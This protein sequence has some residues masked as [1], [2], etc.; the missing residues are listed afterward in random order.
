M[1]G[2]IWGLLAILLSCA[3]AEGRDCS[4]QGYAGTLVID[5][6]AVVPK[7]AGAIEL[8]YTLHEQKP[9]TLL[10]AHLYFEMGADTVIA[11][12]SLQLTDLAGLPLEAITL[13]NVAKPMALH[14]SGEHPADIT[15]TA[16]TN[17]IEYLDGSGIIID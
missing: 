17:Y 9:V 12:V 5:D 16:C 10:S 6:W 8:H 15:V 1:R 2:L 3:A 11:D 4:G 14:L 7:G 13:V